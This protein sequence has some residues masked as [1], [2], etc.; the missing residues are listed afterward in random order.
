[1]LADAA[2]E[3]AGQLRKLL[4]D[5]QQASIQITGASTQVL[6]AAEEHPPIGA[7]CP[8][9]RGGHRAM[10][11]TVLRTVAERTSG[12]IAD[13]SSHAAHCIYA[14]SRSAGS[15]GNSQAVGHL[16]KT[17]LLCERLE[18]IS[19]CCLIKEHRCEIHPAAV[20]AAIGRRGAA[21]TKLSRRR[22]RIRAARRRTRD[23]R[24]NQGRSR[25][26]SFRHHT[27]SLSTDSARNVNG[28]RSPLARGSW[29]VI[30]C[31]R[32]TR[33][34]QLPSLPSSNK[35]QRAD[36]AD[37]ARGCGGPTGRC[38]MSIRPTPWRAEHFAASSIRESGFS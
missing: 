2:N 20:N 32:T 29:K 17:L 5:L 23:P 31:H 9:V 8:S 12:K 38:R 36:R 7:A 27:W 19:D 24:G 33:H 21:N 15:H 37:H 6:T 26:D 25:R 13:D 3:M 34:R 1:M 35:R 11:S 22:E 18:R 14:R 4:Q 10:K 28:F 16:R 30:Q